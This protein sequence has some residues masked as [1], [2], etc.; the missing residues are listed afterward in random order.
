M[1][2][3]KW[4]DINFSLAFASCI[5]K[6]WFSILFYFF[7]NFFSNSFL[8][9][10]K[11]SALARSVGFDSRAHVTHRWKIPG[12]SVTA[13]AVPQGVAWAWLSFV[14]TRHPYHIRATEVPRFRKT[15]HPAV[16]HDNELGPDTRWLVQASSTN[17]CELS[18]WRHHL[19][20]TPT[21]TLF[22]AIE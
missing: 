13:P 17:R 10:C 21:L 18:W 20:A 7:A 9:F 3:F 22:E 11:K 15:H 5:C 6:K 14:A 2:V 16:N 8:S 1:T 12:V 19:S 4:P